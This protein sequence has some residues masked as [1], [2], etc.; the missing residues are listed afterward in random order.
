LATAVPPR[1]EEYA[2]AMG[3]FSPDMLPVLSA[4]ARGGSNAMNTLLLVSFDEHGGTYDHVPPPAA[5]SAR[6]LLGMLPRKFGASSDAVPT[7]FGAAY[8]ALQRLGHG[9]FGG[10]ARGGA[11][12]DARRC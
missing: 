1:P 6:A 3:G 8:A 10:S 11:C 5:A 12:C 9:L 4:L 7:A 2:V